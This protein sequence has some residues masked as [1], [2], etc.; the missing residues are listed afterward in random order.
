MV[1][2]AGLRGVQTEALEPPT[3]QK[4]GK[5]Q[6]S[7]RPQSP[8]VFL[9]N[10]DKSFAY[11]KDCLAA[12]VFENT[13][14]SQRPNGV[15]AFTIDNLCHP[16]TGT[17]FPRFFKKTF[18]V[19]DLLRFRV[20]GAPEYYIILERVNYIR[21]PGH[22]EGYFVRFGVQGQSNN[23]SVTFGSSPKA[24]VVIE[25]QELAPVHFKV[26]M[27]EGVFVACDFEETE[28]TWVKKHG[29]MGFNGYIYK[30]LFQCFDLRILLTPSEEKL[31]PDKADRESRI[32]T[33]KFNITE[34]QQQN[35]FLTEEAYAREE[36][37]YCPTSKELN[38]GT[39]LGK[40]RVFGESDI[41]SAMSP[42]RNWNSPMNRFKEKGKEKS[43]GLNNQGINLFQPERNS[44]HNN[45]QQGEHLR[46][47]PDSQLRSASSGSARPMHISIGGD[48]TPA[49]EFDEYLDELSLAEKLKKSRTSHNPLKK[50]IQAEAVDAS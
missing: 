46:E 25:D 7:L 42:T 10:V 5:T 26:T 48:V 41:S 6:A 22:Y 43:F 19:E 13:K 23:L 44:Q 14:L 38:E 49:D 21:E 2:D 11:C 8:L 12:Y 47:L 36:W 28:G 4:C 50:K 40:A 33:Y 32:S 31:A 34:D 1:H 3:C 29:T 35:A 24:D 27:D 37:G 45:S 30:R 39:M 17:E 18:L 16:E 20:P 15:L 9:C